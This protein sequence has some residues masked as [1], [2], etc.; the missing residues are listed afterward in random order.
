[1]IGLMSVDQRGD[2][3][4]KN[5]TELYLEHSHCN[6]FS[7]TEKLLV[8][9]GWFKI[10]MSKVDNLINTIYKRDNFDGHNF[11]SIYHSNVLSPKISG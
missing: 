3:R 4:L 10:E 7:G 9:D 1:M 6:C 5:Y 11:E 8:L 2:N